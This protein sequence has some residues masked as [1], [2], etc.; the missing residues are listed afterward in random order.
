MFRAGKY[1][2]ISP[3]QIPGTTQPPNQQSVRIL[4]PGEEQHA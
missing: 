3:R 2:L 1:L 4:F